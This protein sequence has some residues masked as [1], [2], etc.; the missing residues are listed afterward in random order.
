MAGPPDAPTTLERHARTASKFVLR[1]PEG[2]RCFM[3]FVSWQ[4]VPAPGSAL[5][6][7][8]MRWWAN[9]LS[10]EQ[11]V[12]YPVIVPESRGLLWMVDL[13][14]Y[15][16][17]ERAWEAVAARDPYCVEPFVSYEAS[18]LLRS[19]VGVK[20]KKNKDGTT[21][22]VA[23]VRADWLFRDSIE[24]GRPSPSTTYYD[25]LFAEQ[26]YP[27]GKEETNFPRN[28]DEWEEFFGVKT[29]TEALAKQKLDTRV[30]A[31]AA[32][33]RDRPGGSIVARQNRV[34]QIAQGF[35][36]ITFRTF[37]AR[38]TAGDTNYLDK[39]GDVAF[40]K[41]KFDADRKSVV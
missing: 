22:V 31:I 19:R 32:G 20:A 1:V 36:G 28:A 7:R 4:A 14:N 30:G 40:G 26:R 6:R 12:A 23:M 37:D 8:V 18:Y 38:R 27:E 24:T 16:W 5:H 33:S 10:T 9:N 25:L 13:R 41:I 3:R 21:P 15:R 17:N 2:E 39:A 11:A 35:W 29:I 34:V